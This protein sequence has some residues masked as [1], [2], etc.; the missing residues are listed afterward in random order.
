MICMHLEN[1][2]SIFWLGAV[3]HTVLDDACV[4]ALQAELL[5]A[6]IASVN[7]RYGKGSLMKLGSQ[8]E[9]DL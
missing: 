3:S 4:H 2:T 8:P 9:N 6:V 7:S 1:H 5:E